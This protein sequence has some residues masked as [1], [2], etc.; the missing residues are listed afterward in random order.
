MSTVLQNSLRTIANNYADVIEGGNSYASGTSF[1]GIPGT[2]SYLEPVTT[3]AS[4][5]AGAGGPYS[6]G[7]V[8]AGTTF[9][10]FDAI[11]IYK[12]DAPPLFVYCSAATD[13][14]NVGAARKISG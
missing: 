7:T 1:K 10:A 4:F 8:Q 14:R 9:A 11:D 12:T 6:N 3:V 2:H 5:T 13:S